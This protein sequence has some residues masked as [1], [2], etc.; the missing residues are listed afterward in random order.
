MQVSLIS[1]VATSWYVEIGSAT[2]SKQGHDMAITIVPGRTAGR[3]CFVSIT[4]KCKPIRVSPGWV[5]LQDWVGAM[6]SLHRPACA[7]AAQSSFAARCNG[8]WKAG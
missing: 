7:F 3:K 5:V 2:T 8:P 6:L 1:D 4:G